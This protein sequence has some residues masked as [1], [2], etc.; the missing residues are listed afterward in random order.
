MKEKR[1]EDKEDL[2]L[3]VEKENDKKYIEQ[4]DLKTA[5]LFLQ[6]YNYRK[7]IYKLRVIPVCHL[8]IKIFNI[9]A[10]QLGHAIK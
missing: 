10:S 5:H 7:T 1:L 4:Y 9:K 6:Y 3:S 8:I 2:I